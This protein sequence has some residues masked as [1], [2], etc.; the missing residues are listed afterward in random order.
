M[1]AELESLA[2]CAFNSCLLNLYRDGSDNMGYHSDNE[3]LYGRHPV[4]GTAPRCALYCLVSS[5]D[6]EQINTQRVPAFAADLLD[7]LHMQ[8]DVHGPSR[9]QLGLVVAHFSMGRYPSQARCC[10]CLAGSASFGATRDF[11]LRNNEDHSR[12]LSFPLSSGDVLV[13]TGGFSLAAAQPPSE[14]HSHPKNTH[15]TDWPPLCSFV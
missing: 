10:G 5:P 8:S 6:C 15:N 4:I 3:P 1:Q 2:G 13:M 14:L 12:K 11:I 9:N 7:K